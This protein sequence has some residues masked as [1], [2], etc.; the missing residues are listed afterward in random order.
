MIGRIVPAVIAATSVI[1]LAGLSF[2]TNTVL[3]V[4]GSMAFYPESMPDY[5]M[6]AVGG[7]L[8]IWLVPLLVVGAVV[9]LLFWT[10][11]PIV[12]ALTL[13]VVVVR[14]VLAAVIATLA[15]GVL[16]FGQLQLEY[17]GIG[18]SIELAKALVSAGTVTGQ[19]FLVCAPLILLSGV[20]LWIWHRRSG[21]TEGPVVE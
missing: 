6:P 13:R 7:A 1:V 16:S 12:A 5:I 18:A 11:L 3:S 4:V 15:V 9:F 21:L 8:R 10:V 20:F 14:S 2:I 17:A 19:S